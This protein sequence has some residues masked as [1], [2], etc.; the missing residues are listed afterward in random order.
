M[1]RLFLKHRTKMKK[2]ILYI[3]TFIT[4]DE[5]TST[6]EENT[7]YIQNVHFVLHSQTQY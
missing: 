2:Y 4:I 5:F 1:S 7:Q 6:L 3:Y